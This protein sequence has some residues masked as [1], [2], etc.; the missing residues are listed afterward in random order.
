MF[1]GSYSNT[2]DEKG[3]VAIPARFRDEL[4]NAGEQGLMITGFDVSGVPCL[5]GFPAAGWQQLVSDLSSKMGAYSQSRVLFET[6]YVGGAQYCQPDKQGRVLLP[7]V[8]RTYAELKDNVTFVGV[9]RKF[10]LFSESGYQNVTQAF[11]AL[12]RENPNMFHDLGI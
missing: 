10:R 8:L 4:R 6:I 11:R 7:P 2:I 1:N 9:G 3:R 5:E 12:L